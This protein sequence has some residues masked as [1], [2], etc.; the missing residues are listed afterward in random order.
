M[1]LSKLLQGT[2]AIKALVA[3]A[4]A[5]AT[6]LGDSSAGAEHLVLSALSQPDGSARRVFEKVGADPE[7]FAA[8]IGESHDAA[9]RQL[10]IEPVGAELLGA[11]SRR[12]VTLN[13]SAV[14]VL[15]SAAARSRTN[16]PAVLGAQV[17]AAAAELEHGTAAR[18]LRRAGID[19]DDLG[20]A[21]EWEIRKAA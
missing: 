1:K 5:H 17:L 21:A 19:R 2:Q 18:A 4:Q 3:G 13:E 11:G 9:L 10:G 6:S 7:A 16:R 20:V 14:R 8:A 15:R 12:P